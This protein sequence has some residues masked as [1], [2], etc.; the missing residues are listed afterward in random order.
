MS[1]GS[2]NPLHRYRDCDNAPM[3]PEVSDVP[4]TGGDVSREQTMKYDAGAPLTHA[5]DGDASTLPTGETGAPPSTIERILNYPSELI[6]KIIP[7]GGIMAGAFNMASVSIGAGI[8]GLPSATD[9][10]G[11]VLSMILLAIIT[12]YSVYSMYILAE[13][14]HNTGI[15]SFEGMARW[16]FPQG[17]YAFS[18]WAAFIRWFH[19]F[20]ACV[21][22]VIS[23]GNCFAPIFTEAHK[24]HPNNSAIT[25][26]NTTNGNRLLSLL[27]WL[28]IML[29]LVIPK[30][31]DSLRYASTLAIAFMLFFCVVVVVHS[32]LN[33]FR[34]NVHHVALNPSH[35][36]STTQD[37]VFLFRTGNKVVV[38]VG[39][40]MFAYVCQIN[41]LEI[42][43]EMSPE[44]RNTRNYT[45]SAIIGMLVTYII[46]ALVAIFGYFDFGSTRISGNSILLMYNPLKEP[47]ML[48]AYLCVLFKLCVAYALQA[49]GARN[50]IYYMIG[51][52][53]KYNNRSCRRRAERK[54]AAAARR[55][56]AGSA[57]TTPSLSTPA[58]TNAD[59][60][61]SEPVTHATGDAAVS[62]KVANAP[63]V[64]DDTPK[65]SE[66]IMSEDTAYIE[67][68]PFWRHLIVVLTL[69]I[70]AMLCGLFIPNINT[71][72]GFAGSISGGFMAFVFPALYH[73]YSGGFSVEKVGWFVYLCTYSLLLCGVV[74]VVWGTCGTIYSIA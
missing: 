10:A 12:F 65:I 42:Y 44:I 21:A 23:A 48:I 37:N 43:W 51:W 53:A 28:V 47:L 40:F 7:P 31:V 18:M 35:A 25:Y 50:S 71:V 15:K 34:E 17:H 3:Q 13:A 62:V 57:T 24:Q 30:A 4:G 70:V 69:A 59:V 22:Y 1:Q 52:Q 55:G 56:N 27:I 9:A 61:V 66:E 46:Y 8:L 73:M 26:F 6:A 19:A 20:S 41:A 54:A 60:H 5:P 64:P 74:G 49:N 39:V 32:V 68:I 63:H 67:N 45:V 58:A 38:S 72:F 36:D 2:E 11:I 33:G 16:L 14:A 29:P